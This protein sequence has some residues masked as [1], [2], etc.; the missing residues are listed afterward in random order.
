MPPHTCSVLSNVDCGKDDSKLNFLNN[1]H[2]IIGN[3]N[4]F[5][6]S[7]TSQ[8]TT[9]NSINNSIQNL[10]DQ[11]QLQSSPVNNF[12]LHNSFPFVDITNNLNSLI[13]IKEEQLDQEFIL[14]P[15]LSELVNSNDLSDLNLKKIMT[16]HQNSQNH[17]SNMIVESPQSLN[18]FFDLD[19]NYTSSYSHQSNN[20]QHHQ[21][22]PHS[23][24]QNRQSYQ[25]NTQ[26]IDSIQYNSA[27]H[28]AQ[29][30]QSAY[31]SQPTTS[32]NS[33]P[34]ENNHSIKK[35]SYLNENEDS[36]QSSFSGYSESVN[37][38]SSSTSN[39][40]LC[41]K[42]RYNS[43]GKRSSNE[44]R[45]GPI[46]IRPRK[47][48][49][50]TLA[51]GR[52]SK[53]AVLTPE[54]E[55]K[56]EQR[57]KRNREAATKCNQKRAEIEGH[58]ETELEMLLNEQAMLSSEKHLLFN[59]KLR[60]EQLL[61]KHKCQLNNQNKIAYL[62]NPLNDNHVNYS[63]NTQMNH[64]FMNNNQFSTNKASISSTQAPRTT[65]SSNSQLF[66]MT[67]DFNNRGSAASTSTTSLVSTGYVPI[68]TN[69][70]N[71][72]QNTMILNDFNV[73]TNLNLQQPLDVYTNQHFNSQFNPNQS[74]SN[75][76]N[77]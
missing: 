18:D 68:Q 29:Q 2:N 69:Y 58:L 62:N 16:N 55:H 63:T 34:A 39:S 71:N 41:N 10:F 43:N 35:Y 42:Q 65:C 46:V 51:S 14:S 33:F 44:K 75:N 67:N 60:L 48:P 25:M 38:N 36:N 50:P 12:E 53:Y 70:S 77:W 15:V 30:T 61:N 73:P 19:S 47:N 17:L 74:E 59:E 27:A 54:E 72:I 64:T 32:S 31:Y 4:F 37:A 26:L 11:S 24:H 66:N 1:N 23:H 28:I 20:Q 52:K 6:N 45:Y 56:R 7:S 5:I 21:Q 22:Q 57:R 3:S 13:S 9:L 8:T 76:M 40:T 49:A